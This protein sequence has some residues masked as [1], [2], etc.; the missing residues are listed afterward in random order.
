MS[1]NKFSHVNR[2]ANHFVQRSPMSFLRQWAPGMA[3]HGW[4][5]RSMV[6]R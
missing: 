1:A 3:T 4:Q 5:I 6:G 2:L